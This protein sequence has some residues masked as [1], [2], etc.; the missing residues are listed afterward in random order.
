LAVCSE[1]TYT[2]MGKQLMK[3]VDPLQLSG[4]TALCGFIWVYDIFAIV[5]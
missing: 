1:A 4:L 5:N 3:K 2:L